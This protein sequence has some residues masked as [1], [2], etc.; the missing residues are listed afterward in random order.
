VEHKENVAL[1]L[2]V[3]KHLGIDKDTAL[4]GM[5]STHPDPG[6]LKVFK[7]V[8]GTKEVHFVYAMAANDPDSTLAIWKNN[9]EALYPERKFLAV[10]LHTRPDRFD[11][12]IQLLEMCKNYIPY[13]QLVLTG[14]KIEQVVAV[15][16]RLK[17]ADERLAVLKHKMPEEVCEFLINS[18]PSPG[19]SVIFGI[20]NV[21]GGGLAVA[22]LF[23]KK[24][25]LPMKEKENSVG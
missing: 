23:Q 12:S 20:G 10:Y 8:A 5:H 16:N 14:E 11:R 17:M 13:D 25:V 15:A 18:S 3:C 2:A 1:A 21:G 24:A 22:K 4:K 6:A 19:L 9:L 7:I